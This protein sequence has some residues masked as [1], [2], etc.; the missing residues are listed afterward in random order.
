MESKTSSGQILVECALALMILAM[1]FA[2]ILD[3]DGHDK[4][5]KHP[6]G[7]RRIQEKQMIDLSKYRNH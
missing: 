1:L 6:I 2:A 4:K 7:K 5:S 3:F